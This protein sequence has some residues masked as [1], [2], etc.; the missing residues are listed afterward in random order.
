ME[1]TEAKADDGE[2]GRLGRPKGSKRKI[3]LSD[4][5]NVGTELSY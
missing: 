2:A 1:E 5:R 4:D 3:K